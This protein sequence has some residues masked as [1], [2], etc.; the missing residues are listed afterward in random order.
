MIV[1]S[2]GLIGRINADCDFFT[3]AILGR[4]GYELQDTNLSFSSSAAGCHSYETLNPKGY[5]FPMYNLF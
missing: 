4:R 2:I 3:S 5:Y 1:F